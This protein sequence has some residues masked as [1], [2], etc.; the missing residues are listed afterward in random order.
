M[1][2]QALF[3]RNL[4]FFLNPGALGI[5][6]GE[7]VASFC[8]MDFSNGVPQIEFKKINY[9]KNKVIKALK[10]KKIP[11]FKFLIKYFFSKRGF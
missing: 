3:R 9:D 7:N 8:L 10:E 6:K 5:S 2:E 1:H 4:K 11:D